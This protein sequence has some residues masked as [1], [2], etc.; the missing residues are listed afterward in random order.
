MSATW[1]G[2]DARHW[3]VLNRLTRLS[4]SG[5]KASRKALSSA[6]QQIAALQKAQPETSPWLA[7]LGAAIGEGQHTAWGL[8]AAQAQLHPARQAG[9]PLLA[10]AR[11]QVPAAVAESWA[12]TL[13][14][15]ASAT[16]P[17][18]AALADLARSDALDAPTL[19]SAA[20]NGDAER[21]QAI[22][23]ELAPGRD[24]S[25]L[26]A[27]AE[28]LAFPL[29]QALRRHWAAAVDPHWTEGYCPICGDWPRLAERSGLEQT[30]HLRC[31]RC[32]AAWRQAGAHCPFC[33]ASSHAARATLLEEG[34]TRQVETCAP[35]HGY[36]K[37]VTT[38]RPWPGGEV[39]LADAATIDL[40]LVALERG[41]MRPAMR[42]LGVMGS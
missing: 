5:R 30:R 1:S 6:A 12:R 16:S 28:P 40:D 13:L 42:L 25:V 15:L 22:G 32:G 20:V 33:T 3:I 27:V 39:C 36:L 41:F 9:A 18:S 11:L 10:G 31:A 19:L 26:A 23:A 24:A 2:P 21:L 14:T 37:V 8:A 29:L 34:G 4:L 38:L 17:E 35:C 7:L